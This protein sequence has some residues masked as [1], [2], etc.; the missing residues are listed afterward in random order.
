MRILF[1]IDS[2]FTG[3]AEFSTL[4]IVR[5]LKENGIQI[6]VCKLKNK[7]PQYDASVFGLDTSDIFTLPSGGFWTKRNVLKKS[8]Q[9]FKPDIIHSVLFNSNLMVRSIRVFDKSFIHLESL[10]NHSYSSERLKDPRVKA[11]KLELHRWFN[12]ITARF[13]TDHFHP[14]G[15]SVMKHFQE[16]LFISSQ[17]MTL[18]YRGR[19]SKNYEVAPTSRTDLDIESDKIVLI[20]VGRQ[21]F[22]KGHDLLVQSVALLPNSI[23]ERIVVLIVG[24]EGNATSSL[25]KLISENKLEETILF[26][27]H[28]TD[29]PALLKM[30]DI[31]IFPSRFEG[32]PGALIEAEAAS[33][34]IICSNVSMML[35]V[36]EP[37]KNALTFDL[38]KVQD[39]SIA[40]E[41]LIENIE[42]RTAFSKKS[43]I[44]F[45]KRFQIESVHQS[46]LL[47]YNNII[48]K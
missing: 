1:V 28:R 40:I 36:V 10:V 19:N 44:I 41:T 20:N 21:D 18:V 16:K 30:A 27:G 12:M 37:N 24:R 38:N 23:K 39:L 25:K 15:A 35:E 43:R 11:Y 48:M 26:L 8:I 6:S 45:E 14:N 31:F 46:M 32:L 17:K 9:E 29:V 22:Q 33:L 7:E 34:P 4:E 5:Y 3:G 47:L 2:F 13:G 42:L